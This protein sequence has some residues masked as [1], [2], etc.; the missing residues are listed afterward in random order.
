MK[1]HSKPF[2]CREC[3]SSFAL[4]LD[5]ERHIKARH[6]VGNI[7]H[8]CH[9]ILCSF[10]S[11]RKDHLNRHIKRSHANAGLPA[12]NYISIINA[13]IVASF[14]ETVALPSAVNTFNGFGSVSMFM[15]AASSGDITTLELLMNSG[16]TT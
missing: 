6:S 13:T 9:V 8:R 15:Q 7:Q 14:S 4:R 10:K 16:F 5:R 11:N 12:K 3:P 2:Q 1:T